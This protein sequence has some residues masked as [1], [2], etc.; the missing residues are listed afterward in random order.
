MY[1]EMIYCLCSYLVLCATVFV[2]NHFRPQQQVDVTSHL[3]SYSETYDKKLFC[4]GSH[5]NFNQLISFTVYN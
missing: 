3:Y 1:H 4:L 5:N 2:T